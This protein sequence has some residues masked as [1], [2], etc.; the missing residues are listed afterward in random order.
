MRKRPS[1]SS[2]C[3]CRGWRRT[4]RRTA[5][6]MVG[7]T[8][9]PM[10]DA[11]R[12]DVELHHGEDA[13]RAASARR[14]ALALRRSGMSEGSWRRASESPSGR[15]T[16]GEASG[17]AASACPA[18]PRRWQSRVGRSTFCCS[19][20][21]CGRCWGV[22][23]PRGG[24]SS[25]QRASASR[26]PC[27]LRVCQRCMSE[28][29]PGRRRLS[30]THLGV[31]TAVPVLVDAAAD[32]CPAFKR[33]SSSPGRSVVKHGVAHASQLETKSRWKPPRVVVPIL[34]EDARVP[35]I[36]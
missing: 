14:R 11:A 9:A 21:C 20:S 26:T 3:C 16:G 8:G 35:T 1:S 7:T 12:G 32:R 24:S 28:S 5:L 33:T 6:A 34:G 13:G 25:E 30:P 29:E 17:G 27:P 31:S 19:C 2:R 36:E 4:V 22:A 10:A 23:G 15:G 18:R